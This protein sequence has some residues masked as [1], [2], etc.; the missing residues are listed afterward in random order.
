M[1]Q[2]ATNGVELIHVQSMTQLDHHMKLLTVL[3][4]LHPATT[5]V[6]MNASD[7]TQRDSKKTAALA[8]Q[9]PKTG[10]VG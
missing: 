6:E 4:H 2:F 1:N 9:F 5:I 8:L 3:V 7:M 10:G